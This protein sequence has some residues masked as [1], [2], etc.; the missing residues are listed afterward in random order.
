MLVEMLRVIAVLVAAI[1]IGNWYLDET[2]KNRA[3]G[4]PRYKIY[5]SLPGLFVLA[6]LLLFPVVLWVLNR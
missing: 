5:F 2:K 6:A 3:S 1:L 4:E